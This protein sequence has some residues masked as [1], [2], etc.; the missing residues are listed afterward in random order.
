MKLAATHKDSSVR[1]RC[2]TE[3]FE[4]FAEFPTY[5][6][7]LEPRIDARLVETI[8]DMLG[9]PETTTEVRKGIDIL[10]Q[11]LPST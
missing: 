9:D 3:Y 5:L 7:D 2:F 4:R 10:L 1:K 8:Q 6:F 11:R